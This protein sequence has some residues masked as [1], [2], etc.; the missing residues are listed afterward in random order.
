MKKANPEKRLPASP[1]ASE[2][3]HRE[4]TAC[5][6]WPAKSG[7]PNRRPI[8][9]ASVT[10]NQLKKTRCHRILITSW[11][12]WWASPKG[13]ALSRNGSVTEGW[14]FQR[15]HSDR[16]FIARNVVQDA[17]EMGK[18]RLAA[19][20]WGD[21]PGRTAGDRAHLNSD[22]RHGPNEI[23]K[24]RRMVSLRQVAKFLKTSIG[25]A[26]RALR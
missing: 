6:E 1:S 5:Q 12:R 15:P 18:S 26:Q 14:E 2:P 9:L 22:L 8:G 11:K 10:R 20:R 3:D 13:R 24:L 19:C 25:R 17:G 21:N 4:S 16:H 7:V 23:K